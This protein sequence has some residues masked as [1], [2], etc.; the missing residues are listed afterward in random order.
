[1]ER[2]QWHAL[3]FKMPMST[4][5][6]T[7]DDS[8]TH[9][10]PLKNVVDNLVFVSAVNIRSEYGTNYTKWPLDPYGKYLAMCGDRHAHVFF[11]YPE[12]L[13]CTLSHMKT[14]A[15]CT[16]ENNIMLVIEENVELLNSSELLYCIQTFL[17]LKMDYLQLHT[18][19]LF[20]DPCPKVKSESVLHGGFT[21]IFSEKTFLPIR[22]PTMSTK[23]YLI[24]PNFAKHMLSVIDPERIQPIHVDAMLSLE[25]MSTFPNSSFLY[26]NITEDNVLSGDGPFKIVAKVDQSR[27]IP[28]R[29]P[30]HDSCM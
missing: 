17:R 28:H 11:N 8:H 18:W 22:W 4:C 6:I 7:F 10:S 15:K 16:L 25:A 30:I 12:A 21:S 1:M 3:M 9:F 5:V 27:A 20:S 13:G 19:G 26:C 29:R 14:W 23:A 2:A 24:S